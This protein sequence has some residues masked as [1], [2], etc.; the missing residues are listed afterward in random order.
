MLLVVDRTS[1]ST[2]IGDKAL[3]VLPALTN[4]VIEVENPT[5]PITAIFSSSAS[6][7]TL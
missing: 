3:D 7:F 5:F 1:L 4:V 6:M 2:L